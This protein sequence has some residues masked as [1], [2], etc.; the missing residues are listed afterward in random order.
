MPIIVTSLFISSYLTAMLVIFPSRGDG[1][2]S[3]VVL[4]VLFSLACTSYARTIIDGPGYFPFFYP[5]QSPGDYAAGGD[6]SSLLHSDD[7]SPS[8]I[9][10][11]KEQVSWAAQRAK[12]NRCIFSRIARRIVVRPDHFCGWTTTWIGKRNHKFFILFNFWGA[13]Y[14]SAF[15]WWD[16]AT[17]M[18]EVADA[19]PSGFL[20]VFMVYAFLGVSFALITWS[21]VCSHADGMC[22]NVTSW[23]GWNRIPPA[24]FDRGCVANC[25]DVCGSRKRWFCWMCPM[26][27]WRAQTN[28]D[29]VAQWA[30]YRDDGQ[31][32][33]D[34]VL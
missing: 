5:L 20:I 29:F 8:G 18:G 23:E 19:D 10:S 34:S 33:G 7:L 16:I 9:A 3:S 4:S 22:R 28:Q 30:P 14:L 32:I 6:S 2:L 25:E 31:P 15:A 1:V 12:P 24:R 11:T 13:L 21:F 17:I 26:S 27:P